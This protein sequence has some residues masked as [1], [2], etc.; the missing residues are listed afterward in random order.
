MEWIWLYS[1]WLKGRLTGRLRSPRMLAARLT[2]ALVCHTPLA[3]I[4]AYMLLAAAKLLRTRLRYTFGQ[5][6]NLE[7][8]SFTATTEFVPAHICS[9]GAAVMLASLIILSLTKC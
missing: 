9:G 8:N 7:F 1:V 4:Y 2:L 3:F 6:E 5:M